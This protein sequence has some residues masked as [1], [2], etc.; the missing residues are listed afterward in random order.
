MIRA[1]IENVLDE[2]AGICKLEEMELAC[3]NGNEFRLMFIAIINPVD[4]S[5][6]SFMSALSSSSLGFLMMQALFR[7]LIRNKSENSSSNFHI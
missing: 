6:V 2:P 3:S 5:G 4:H 7:N 1:I